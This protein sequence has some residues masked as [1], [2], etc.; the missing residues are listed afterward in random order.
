MKLRT[1]LVLLV[2]VAIGVFTALNWSAFV[3]PT[4][5]SLGFSVIYAPL[6][7]VLLGLLALVSAL[8]F[9]FVLFLQTSVLM[10]AR[11]HS[12]E[13]NAQRELA[14]QAETSRLTEL[15]STVVAEFQQQALREAE[16]KADLLARLEQVER[17]LREEIEQSENAILAT[18]GELEDRFEKGGGSG[19]GAGVPR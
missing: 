5:L 1:V 4:T 7:M 14:T 6:G 13:L 17:G 15:R 11:R 16:A 9:V 2:L 19:G 12:K 10:E 3:A 18:V 8:F